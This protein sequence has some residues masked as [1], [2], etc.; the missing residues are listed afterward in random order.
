MNDLTVEVVGFQVETLLPLIF[1]LA[2]HI[3][4]VWQAPQLFVNTLKVESTYASW[5]EC[6][7][8][9]GPSFFLFQSTIK[10][11]VITLLTYKSYSF[12]L[13][14]LFWILIV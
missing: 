8:K 9:E 1:A 10:I 13:I 7:M 6:H 12:R 11:T 4:G 14:V 3:G 5:L 2:T